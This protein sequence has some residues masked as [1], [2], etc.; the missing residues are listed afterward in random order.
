VSHEVHGN[1]IEVH[2][3]VQP[4]ARVESEQYQ[5][6]TLPNARL[7]G[8]V[9]KKEDLSER[10]LVPLLFAEVSLPKAP[11]GCRPQIH[12]RIPEDRW[13]FIWDPRRKC[14]YLLVALRQKDTG[15]LRFT[16]HWQDEM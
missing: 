4:Y 12:S 10:Q 1:T 2:Q 9:K 5:A 6:Q 11:R 16:V 13:V 7:A 15:D 3:P 8:L 14:G